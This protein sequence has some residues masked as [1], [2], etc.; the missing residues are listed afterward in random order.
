MCEVCIC[1]CVKYVSSDIPV[2]LGPAQFSFLYHLVL[3]VDEITHEQTQNFVILKLF[4]N[5]LITLEPIQGFKI[6]VRVELMSQCQ[7]STL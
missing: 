5:V 7:H 6:S 2:W 1:V 4:L 3:L